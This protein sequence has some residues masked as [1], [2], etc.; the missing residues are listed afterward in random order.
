MFI[1]ELKDKADKSGRL[2]DDE[3]NTIISN[4]QA[5]NP[6]IGMLALYGLVNEKST[7][8]SNDLYE[9]WID[10]YDGQCNKWLNELF[11][12]GKVT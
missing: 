7:T 4:I 8:L 11:R 9:K 12:R 5:D 10:E 2:S 3:L 1:E 6:K